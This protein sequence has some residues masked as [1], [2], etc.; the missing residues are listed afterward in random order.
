[1][2]WIDLDE[3]AYVERREWL[4]RWFVATMVGE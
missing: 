3:P 1:M 2:P 4:H